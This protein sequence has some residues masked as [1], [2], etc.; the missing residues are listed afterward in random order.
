MSELSELVA[1]VV[2]DGIVDAEEVENIR[3]TIFEDG[4][5]D[6]DE[7]DA[8]FEINDAVSG[9]DNDPAWEDLFVEAVAS[10][11]LADE[12]TP[13]VIDDDEADYLI[14]KIE[15]DGEVDEV[16]KKLLNSIKV[17][18]TAISPKLTAFMDKNGI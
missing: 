13:N 2:E 4:V 16:E 5:I 12:D 14:G 3:Q 10:H 1:S 11:V 15:G 7:C 17:K 6:R 18:A 8:L 9:N